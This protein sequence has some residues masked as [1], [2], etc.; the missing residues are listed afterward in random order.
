MS[1]RAVP[2]EEEKALRLVVFDSRR[3]LDKRLAVLSV[4]TPKKHTSA[5]SHLGFEKG[6]Y[7]I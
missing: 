4:L 5:A 2:L 3:N 1:Y 6:Q 7:F